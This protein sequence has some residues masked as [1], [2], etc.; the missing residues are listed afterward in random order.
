MLLPLRDTYKYEYVYPYIMSR[1]AAIGW[2]LNNSN[3]STIG[4]TF[5]D[6][7]ELMGAPLPSSARKFRP[8]WANDLS[9]AQA[10]NG[11]MRYGWRIQNVDMGNE[12]VEF[13]NVEFRKDETV[14]EKGGIEAHT[15]R[16]TSV[17]PYEFEEIARVTMSDYFDTA[18]FQ[19][20]VG[21]VNKRFDLVSAD[22]TIVGDAKFYTMVNGKS[23][24]PAKFS[25]IAE[26]VWLLE[27]LEAKHKFLVFGNDRRVPEE[28]LRRYG[29]L[30]KDVEFY[31]VNNQGKIDKINGE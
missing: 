22:Q 17:S 5:S 13:K 25:T 9:H 1:Y 30:V 7:E 21:H 14:D 28:W 26:H 15:L 10:K 24:P 23:I 11:W 29:N 2:H 20:K 12:K 31:F 27:K 6:I 18:L 8:W 3:A 16:D 4:M 19:D